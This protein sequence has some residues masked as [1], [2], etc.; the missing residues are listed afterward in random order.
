MTFLTFITFKKCHD[1][2]IKQSE[3]TAYKA[4]N[5]M[6]SKDLQRNKKLMT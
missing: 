2:Q 6:L 3:I 4:G 5:L 1:F